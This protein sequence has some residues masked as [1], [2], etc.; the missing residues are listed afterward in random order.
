VRIVDRKVWSITCSDCGD[1]Y[2][3][4]EGWIGESQ[5]SVQAL[6]FAVC[7][8]HPGHEAWV[9]VFLKDEQGEG[10]CF[11]S[12][13]VAEGATAVDAPVTRKP[14]TD[15]RLRREL[16]REEALSHPDASFFWEVVDVLYLE[17]VAIGAA[18]YSDPKQG[19]R[20]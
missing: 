3:Y 2:E 8:G 17:D 19:P 1:N 5:E 9:D 14:G 13:L 4:V 7:H 6:Y 15:S 10:E 20:Q 11:S 16:K 18:M 12:R